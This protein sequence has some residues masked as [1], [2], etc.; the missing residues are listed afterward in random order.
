MV[1]GKAGRLVMGVGGR[2]GSDGDAGV[3]VSWCELTTFPI[4]YHFFSLS[5]VASSSFFFSS[6]VTRIPQ[7]VVR[8]VEPLPPSCLGILVALMRTT[9]QT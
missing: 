7:H 8:L 2:S 5:P 1:S 9:R 6:I 4:S 3:G